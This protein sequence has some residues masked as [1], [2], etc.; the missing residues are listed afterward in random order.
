MHV[1][2]THTVAGY[3]QLAQSGL[4]PTSATTGPGT[5]PYG[6]ETKRK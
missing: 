1:V 2:E 5:Y 6:S 4:C 3:V